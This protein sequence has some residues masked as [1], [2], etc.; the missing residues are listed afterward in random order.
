MRSEPAWGPHTVRWRSGS[1]RSL[2]QQ[3][4]R[5]EP[6]SGLAPMKSQCRP[7][8]GPTRPPKSRS[9]CTRSSWHH[10]WST[11]LR[12]SLCVAWSAEFCSYPELHLPHALSRRSGQQVAHR[13]P[14]DRIAQFR[15]QFHHRR[16][17][18]APLGKTRVRN[19]QL[20]RVD[21]E[22]AIKQN[23]DIYGP[24]ALRNYAPAPELLLDFGD[25]RQQLPREQVR[26]GLHYKVQ[27]PALIALLLGLG[28]VNGGN[29]R[30]ANLA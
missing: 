14:A 20:R 16:K 21:F 1:H 3:A 27:K 26:L 7:W 5:S 10:T 8:A 17:H 12:W 22:V 13:A 19:G 29:A 2:E 11:A 4:R 18:E 28:L 25:A 30:D 6:Q 9:R 15:R 23:V 24:R